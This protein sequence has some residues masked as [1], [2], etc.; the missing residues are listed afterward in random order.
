MFF[1]FQRFRLII[2]AVNFQ[3]RIDLFK[4]DQLTY[5]Y[6][7]LKQKVLRLFKEG[8]QKVSSTEVFQALKY[9]ESWVSG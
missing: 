3:P 7:A 2:L 9:S 6:I 1:D 5:L 8:W 4:S